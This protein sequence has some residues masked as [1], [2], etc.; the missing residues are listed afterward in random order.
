MS[1]MALIRHGMQHRA[2]DLEIAAERTAE[3]RRAALAL[4]NA[5]VHLAHAPAPA[6]REEHQL[7]ADRP[8]RVEVALLAIQIHAIS[9]EPAE[10]I[11]D[12]VPPARHGG[13]Q[14]FGDARLL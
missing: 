6:Q 7:R 13:E 12:A 9:L 4:A 2:H 11:L 14:R 1:C 8:A 5:D 3:A 10:R